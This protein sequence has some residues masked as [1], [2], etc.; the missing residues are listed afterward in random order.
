MRVLGYWCYLL[1]LLFPEGAEE[2]LKLFSREGII[3]ALHCK[4]ETCY[5]YTSNQN[6]WK[7]GNVSEPLQPGYHFPFFAAIYSQL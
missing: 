1:L 6:Q 4:F 7:N 2:E 5:Y 3:A